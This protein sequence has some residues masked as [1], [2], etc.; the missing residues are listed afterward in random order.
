MFTYEQPYVIHY[1]GEYNVFHSG[2]FY[3]TKDVGLA[4]AYWLMLIKYK[5]EGKFVGINQ[6]WNLEKAFELLDLWNQT[7]VRMR[8]TSSLLGDAFVT[9]DFF[10][11]L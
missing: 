6:S 10:G 5:M 9:P 1:M 7:D 8:V 3:R 11:H 4:I 2:A